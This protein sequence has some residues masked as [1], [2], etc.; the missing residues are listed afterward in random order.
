MTSY[1]SDSK[2]GGSPK[3]VKNIFKNESRKKG[4]DINSKMRGI[5]IISEEATVY[6]KIHESS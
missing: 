5:P 3:P 6:K 2:T 4:Q 1:Y